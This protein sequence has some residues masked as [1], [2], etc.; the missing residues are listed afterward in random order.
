MLFNKHLLNRTKL[1]LWKNSIVY[2]QLDEGPGVARG[3][4]IILKKKNI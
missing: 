3:K 4:K 2:I 1:S